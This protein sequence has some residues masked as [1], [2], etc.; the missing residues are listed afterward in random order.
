MKKIII[1]GAGRAGL[2]AAL[3]LEKKYKH[4]RDIK[5]TLIDRHN[6][7]LLKF[8]LAEA[9]AT[10]EDLVSTSQLEE[11]LA[12]PFRQ[13]LLGKVINFVQGAVSKV[14]TAQ[15]SVQLNNKRLEYDYL[16]L[17]LGSVPNYVEVPGAKRFGLPL[18]SMPDALRVRN[19]LNFIIQSHR[20]D[21]IKKKIRIVVAGGGPTGVEMAG[22]LPKL[23]DFLAWENSY[24]KENLEIVL[25]EAERRLLPRY[26]YE[27]GQDVAWRLRQL[28][29]RVE[30]DKKITMVEQHL[31]N[32]VDG[33]RM[34][35]DVLVWATGS[36]PDKIL[37]ETD[38][39]VLG[40]SGDLLVNEHLQLYGTG[41]VFVIGSQSGK[42]KDTYDPLQH[43]QY[44]AYALPKFIVNQ[45]PQALIPKSRALI[46]QVGDKWAIYASKF[47]HFT[48]W[49]A[50]IYGRW[51]NHKYRR[52]LQ[53]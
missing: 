20:L 40:K 38:K 4:S 26:S 53:G 22:R 17:A 8:G 39:R 3:L 24:P 27:A 30:S 46:L 12:L 33:E 41:D 43:A 35:Y 42:S 31:L 15:K 2:N 13:I 16:V 6:Y 7:H 50:Y 48:G 47:R 45:K 28:G 52:Y 18:G 19:E 21:A 36:V 37:M 51:K 49:L 1:A 32:F 23:L 29:V 9:A 34:E 11:Q 14:D 5:L 44:L 25:V 10:D